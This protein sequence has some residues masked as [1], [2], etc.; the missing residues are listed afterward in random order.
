MAKKNTTPPPP[1][2]RPPN[3][4][5]YWIRTALITVLMFIFVVYFM[6]PRVG[7]AAYLWAGGFALAILGYFVISYY[8]LRR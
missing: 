1:A 7:N 6:L 2:G 4:R 3:W 8:F 5:W